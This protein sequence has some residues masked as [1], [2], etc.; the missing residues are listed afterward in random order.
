MASKEWVGSKWEAGI[1]SSPGQWR[2]GA[3]CGYCS[4]GGVMSFCPPPL[5]HVKVRADVGRACGMWAGGAGAGLARPETTAPC[6]VAVAQG[7]WHATGLLW[8]AER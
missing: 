8:H 4:G 6:A 3:R 2:G 7:L 5:V 1:A